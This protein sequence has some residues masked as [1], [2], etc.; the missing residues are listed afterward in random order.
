VFELRA[1][2]YRTAYVGNG[3]SD[4]CPAIEAD[5]VFAKAELAD[6]CRTEEID[7]IQFD[8]FSEVQRELGE[9]A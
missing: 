6:L 3:H 2:G 7:F 8:R 5:L 1:E 4:L 9:W